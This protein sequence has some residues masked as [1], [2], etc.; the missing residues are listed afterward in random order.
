LKEIEKEKED[1]ER[2]MKQ[3][4]FAKFMRN[5]LANCTDNTAILRKKT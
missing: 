3:R 1:E 4:N 2:L 5:N